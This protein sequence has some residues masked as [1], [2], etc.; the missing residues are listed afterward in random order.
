MDHS[1]SGIAGEDSNPGSRR[2]AMEIRQS[3]AALW[4][5]ACIDEQRV[6]KGFFFQRS[7]SAPCQVT[8]EPVTAEDE[9]V[10][11]LRCRIINKVILDRTEERV[12]PY[13]LS[14]FSRGLDVVLPQASSFHESFDP[15][16]GLAAFR[17]RNF[18]K[19]VPS[20]ISNKVSPPTPPTLLILLYS[21]YHSSFTPLPERVHTNADQS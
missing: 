12:A 6:E 4:N 19:S 18:S 8:R 5:E 7:V 9:D 16:K 21:R 17:T 15:A 3:V 11:A 10:Y 14:P 2:A 13:K 1:E 20:L